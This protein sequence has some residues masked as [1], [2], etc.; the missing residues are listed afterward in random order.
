MGFKEYL[1]SADYFTLLR[2]PGIGVISAKKIIRARRTFLLDFDALKKLGVILKRAKYFIT[3]KGKY[4]DKVYKFNQNF[5][6]T[7]LIY[8]E[9]LDIN[10]KINFE[11]LSLFSNSYDNNYGYLAKEKSLLFNKLQP[12]K[13]DKIKCLTGSL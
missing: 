13:E 4:F 10:K 3:C 2:I 7:N 12:T 5:I 11:Q 8:Q 9:R 6:E 1:N